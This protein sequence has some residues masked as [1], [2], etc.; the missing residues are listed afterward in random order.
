MLYWSKTSSAPSPERGERLAHAGEPIGVE[1]PEIDALLEVDL[2]VSG[3]L[4]RPVPA[5]TGIDGV[6]GAALRVRRGLLR[7][8][9]LLGSGWRC[10][11]TAN[12]AGGT[13]ERS[14]RRQRT[15]R[16]PAGRA[17]GAHRHSRATRLADSGYGRIR[18]VA[19]IGTCHRGAHGSTSPASALPRCAA[20]TTSDRLALLRGRSWRRRL[21][22]AERIS[23]SRRSSSRPD[24]GLRHLRHRAGACRRFSDRRVDRP[25]RR[26]SCSECF[27]DEVLAEAEDVYVAGCDDTVSADVTCWTMPEKSPPWLLAAD[28]SVISRTDRIAAAARSRARPTIH[29]ARRRIE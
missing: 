24:P 17:P 13:S 5:M 15:T 10:Y 28:A 19:V 20:A 9:S 18:C 8:G 25:G 22:A 23:T 21:H 4:Q 6:V 27:R 14:G 2:H 26:T 3:R 12:A 16:A 7:H 1:P 29:S 11:S